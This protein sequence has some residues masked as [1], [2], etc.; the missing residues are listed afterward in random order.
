RRDANEKLEEMKG[1]GEISEDDYHRYREKNDETIHEY[2]KK[3]E[4][5]VEFKSKQLR[6]I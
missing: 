3:V 2:S 1:N 4:E 6:T 5:L